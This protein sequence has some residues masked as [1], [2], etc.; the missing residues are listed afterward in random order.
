[1]DTIPNEFICPITCE[2]MS[3]PVLCED[4]YTY[5]RSA[6][7][8]LSDSLSPMTCLLINKTKLIP[9]IRLKESIELFILSNS[10]I[11]SLHN[12]Y[13]SSQPNFSIIEE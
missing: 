3:D 7:M 5:E 12:E 13:K 1:M 2:L 10:Q 11:S 6:I 4:R 9:N 8:S